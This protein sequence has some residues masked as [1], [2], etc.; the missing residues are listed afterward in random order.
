MVSIQPPFPHSTADSPFFRNKTEPAFFS[1]QFFGFKKNPIT[2]PSWLCETNRPRL[3]HRSAM[4]FTALKRKE[5]WLSRVGAAVSTPSRVSTN[6][7]LTAFRCVPELA[8]GTA[9]SFFNRSIERSTNRERKLL[10][11]AKK[12]RCCV[13]EDLLAEVVKICSKGCQ[14]C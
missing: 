4:S 7:Q 13:K 3:G 14:G 6:H 12:G 9:V 10:R 5:K 8:N 11:T 2:F 1:Q